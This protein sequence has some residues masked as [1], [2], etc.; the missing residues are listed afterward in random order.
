MKYFKKSLF[1]KMTVLLLFISLLPL[2]IL[3]YVANIQGQKAYQNVLGLQ[4]EETAIQTKDKIERLLSFH[5]NNI[6]TWSKLDNFKNNTNTSKTIQLIKNTYNS[7]EEVIVFDKNRNIIHST[8][9]KKN[10]RIEKWF[11][12]LRYKTDI[13]VYEQNE[14]SLNEWS[15]VNFIAPI[16]NKNQIIKYLLFKFNIG[17][18]FE[19]TNDIK[20]I[21]E[22]QSKDAYVILLNDHGKVILGP[23]FLVANKLTAEYITKI[24]TK[25]APK[26]SYLEKEFSRKEGHS[27]TVINK[28]SSLLGYS[29]YFSSNDLHNLNWSVLTIENTAIAY[30]PIKNLRNEYLI[31]VFITIGI[32]LFFSL[33]FSKRLT[34]PIKKLEYFTKKVAKGN[35]DETLKLNLNDEIGQLATAFNSLVEELKGTRDRLYI[36]LK[37]AE[38]ASKEKSNFLAS[39]SHE[40]RTPMNAIIAMSTLLQE[41]PLNNEQSKYVQIFESSSETLLA[42]INDILDFSKIEAGQIQIE[43][44]EFDL[45]K[46]LSEL[47]SVLA[48]IAHN[49]N[50]DINLKI[51]PDVSNVIKSDP[52]R[53][54]QILMNLISNA[55]KFTST[56][57]ISIKVERLAG[58][59][60]FVV[61]DT[62]IGI[63]KS[64]IQL[65]FEHFSQSDSST[66]RKYGGSGLGLAI[67]QK[68]VE[69]LGGVITVDSEEGRGSTFHFFI[70]YTEVS[71]TDYCIP[72]LKLYI[73]NNDKYL[74]YNSISLAK[75]EKNWDNE[76]LDSNSLVLVDCSNDFD[77]TIISIENSGISPSN[78][79]LLV[80]TILI[81]PYQEYQK[82]YGYFSTIT[83]PVDIFELRNICELY[84]NKKVLSVDENKNHKREDMNL[85]ILVVDDHKNNQLIIRSYFKKTKAQITIAE[86]GQE[87]LD[88]CFLDNYD[89]V[90]MDMQMPV[91]DG[92]TATKLI[93]ERE[94]KEGRKPLT[95]IGLSANALT[96][97]IDK[98]RQAG[99]DDYLT[100]PIKKD[101]LFNKILSITKTDLNEIDNDI[102]IDDDLIDL[103]P[104][105]IKN[106]RVEIETLKNAVEANDLEIVARMGHSLKGS[107]EA[108]GL[109]IISTIGKEIELSTKS[110]NSEFI[111]KLITNFENIINQI[112]KKYG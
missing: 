6:K 20:L 68:L 11:K 10:K 5:Q 79:I 34:D 29:G 1:A 37:Q 40:I 13:L 88:I 17:E 65:I 82:V 49:K 18:I 59:L 64:K 51:N 47:L 54:R 56:G 89:I 55:I 78:I 92:I 73:F 23:W 106:S 43:H 63:A 83:K 52:T 60:N 102:F 94:S 33:I 31:F 21:K 84:L 38:M 26:L 24:W 109:K 96:E 50:L 90:L 61:T 108:Y 76:Y 48:V 46:L 62:G 101:I 58:Y 36:S 85:R 100:K 104:E 66:T 30:K 69:L 9:K 4:L 42:L 77:K 95:I 80:P 93:R 8:L 72:N 44:I 112:E 3:T 15:Y 99:C 53:L 45:H 81:K 35:L 103:M 67:S 71:S 107:G 12:Q 41:T 75:V 98:A 105:F 74:F 14:K 7:Y 27:T 22:G 111:E 19:I 110:N 28:T 87:A 2:L 16:Y 32:V 57:S 91:M 25:L 70:P 86:N 97:E 39:M